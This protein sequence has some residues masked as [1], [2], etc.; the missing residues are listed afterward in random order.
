M[1]KFLL[2]III[3][4]VIASG[5]TGCTKLPDYAN[6]PENV[7]ISKRVNV[8]DYGNGVYYFPY[9]EANFANALSVFIR[10]HQNLKLVSFSGNGNGT[11][12]VDKGYFVVFANK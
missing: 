10:D 7:G 12:G 3:G 11:Y 6:D 9:D 4:I 5:M 1:R 2:V 8:V